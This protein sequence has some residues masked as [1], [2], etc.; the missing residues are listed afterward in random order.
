MI[1]GI[2]IIIS[3]AMYYTYIIDSFIP[4]CNE[5][6]EIKEEKICIGEI[7]FTSAQKIGYY[8]FIAI[9]TLLFVFVISLITS[10]D[11]GA[12][13]MLVFIYLIIIL[14]KFVPIFFYIKR[15][16]IVLTKNNVIGKYRVGVLGTNTV[17]L[18]LDKLTNI[19]VAN[20]VFN[21]NILLSAGGIDGIVFS[22]LLNADEFKD[23][24]GKTI[25][26]R[27]SNKNNEVKVTEISEN[28]EDKFEK[29]QKL[30]DKNYITEEEYNKKRESILKDM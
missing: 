26:S 2:S 27:S 4:N 13:S 3:V 15:E 9:L 29:L 21:K 12:I 19:T 28:I 25:N 8:A 11:S 20:R 16:Y 14:V 1:I 10:E 24:V 17:N 7:G 6:D 23:I 30:K 22:N 5:I 18:T